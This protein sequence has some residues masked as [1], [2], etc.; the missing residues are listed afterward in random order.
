MLETI[1]IRLFDSH[2]SSSFAADRFTWNDQN[3]EAQYELQYSV[4]CVDNFRGSKA[5]LI[6][7]F[8]FHWSG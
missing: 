2:R 4:S 8:E 6:V 1:C 3:F 5:L 7:L